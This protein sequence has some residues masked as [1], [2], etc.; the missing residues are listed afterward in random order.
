MSVKHS[1]TLVLAAVLFLGCETKEPLPLPE[2]R[3]VNCGQGDVHYGQHYDYYHGLIAS[4]SNRPDIVD[5]MAC[6]LDGPCGRVWCTRCERY[7][8]ERIIIE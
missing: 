5:R 3:I 2:A 1:T 4:K 6:A 8:C 7:A